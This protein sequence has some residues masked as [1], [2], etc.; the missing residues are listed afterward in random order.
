MKILIINAGGNIL[1]L[2]NILFH[3]GF[4][5]KVYDGEDILSDFDLVFL[6]GIGSFDKIIENL[7]KINLIQQLKKFTTEIALILLVFVL[8]C[9]FYLIIVKKANLKVWD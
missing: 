6:P 5:A 8:V 7:N 9:K 4:E 1:S 3:C 2:K